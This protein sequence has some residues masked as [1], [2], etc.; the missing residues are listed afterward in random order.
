MGVFKSR[1]GPLDWP[2]KSKLWAT[3]AYN[4]SWF[5]GTV[6]A[7]TLLGTPHWSHRAISLSFYLYIFVC[8]YVYTYRIPMY[9]NVFTYTN[10]YIQPGFKFA[11]PDR[12]QD[13]LKESCIAYAT[14]IKAKPFDGGCCSQH[15]FVR[16]TSSYFT[17]LIKAVFLSSLRMLM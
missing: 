2:S 8:I 7:K 12:G 11:F 5:S 13:V 10:M 14:C 3:C 17:V 6:S 1:G 4:R 15:W 16:L 9:I